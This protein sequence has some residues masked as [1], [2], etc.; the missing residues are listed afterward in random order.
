MSLAS[1]H[2][3]PTHDRIAIESK[4]TCM[5]EAERT[6][7]HEEEGAGKRRGE[8]AV[9]D[10]GLSW[11]AALMRRPT[12]PDLSCAQSTC[13]SVEKRTLILRLDAMGV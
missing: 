3:V 5:R 10:G 12:K 4:H 9:M 11:P 1:Q 13:C 2:S 6:D 8:E 7:T